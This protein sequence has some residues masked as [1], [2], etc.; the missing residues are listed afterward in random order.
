MKIQ[1]YLLEPFFLF[2]QLIFYFLIS[3]ITFLCEFFFLHYLQFVCLSICLSVYLFFFICRS[4]YLPIGLSVYLP[5]YLYVYPSKC[6]SI[7]LCIFLSFLCYFVS[8]FPWRLKP[9]Q[10]H[11]RFWAS[12]AQARSSQSHGNLSASS[13]KLKLD[14]ES[15]L[16]DVLRFILWHH[17]CTSLNQWFSVF[18][19]GFER[20]Q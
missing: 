2:L 12:Q 7:S 1:S 8:S 9:R 4:I 17:F 18:P 5:I 6:L 13:A 11:G 19:C 3:F 16:F 10:R 14:S 20:M 15:A